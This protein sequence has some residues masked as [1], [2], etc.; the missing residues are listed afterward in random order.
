MAIS[1][2]TGQGIGKLNETLWAMVKGQ[3]Q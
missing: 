3:V 1:A 2:V